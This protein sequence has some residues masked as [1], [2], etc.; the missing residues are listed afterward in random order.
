[1]ATT[2][3]PDP[4]KVVTGKCRLSYAYLNEPAE[5]ENGV[6]KYSVSIIIPKSDKVTLGKIAKALAAAT[7]VGKNTK[8]KW[9]GKVPANLRKPI[10]DGDAERPD[11]PAY[12]NSFYFSAKS[13]Q[14]PAIV[15]MQLNAILDKESIY[16]GMYGRVSVNFYPFDTKGNGIAVGLNNV[17]KVADGEPLAGRT[18]NPNEDFAEAFVD[19][20]APADDFT[21]LL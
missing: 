19:G 3:T 5:D 20:D 11:D 14:K 6:K 9:G 13:V 18:S 7:E 15:D 12:A 1:M 8:T 4:C 21:A 10:H 17:Q 16:S 2:N